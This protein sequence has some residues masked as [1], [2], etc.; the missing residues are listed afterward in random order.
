MFIGYHWLYCY[1]QILY[2]TYGLSAINSVWLWI[3]Q[4]WF[5]FDCIVSNVTIMWR[6]FCSAYEFNQPLDKW[7]DKI[8]KVVSMNSMFSDAQSFCQNL[9]SWDLDIENVSTIYMFHNCIELIPIYPLLENLGK[10]I[11]W[12]QAWSR[13]KQLKSANKFRS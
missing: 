8:H 11:N 6:M 10:N 3:S 9:N 12:D 1:T 2:V 5:P 7:K 13:N 4:L